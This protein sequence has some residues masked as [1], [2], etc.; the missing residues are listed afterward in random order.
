MRRA[1]IYAAFDGHQD[2]NFKPYVFK[3]ADFGKTWASIASDLPGDGPVHVITEHHRNR[4]LLFV[5]TEFGVFFS[6]DGGG[7]WV[8]LRNN[9]P[10]VAVHD[11]VIHPRENDLVLGT[12]GRGFWIL[13]DLAPIE[14]LTPDTLSG[15]ARLFPIRRAWQLHRFARG[16]NATGQQRFIA[17]NPPDGAIVSYYARKDD[18]VEI[19]VIDA[20]GGVIRRLA[21][22]KAASRTGIFRVT[23]DLRYPSPAP[24]RGGDGEDEGVFSG[25]RGPFVLPGKYDVRMRVGGAEQ[26]QTVEVVPD[27]QVTLSTADRGTWHQ[28]LLRLADMYRVSRASLTMLD[29]LRADLAA[30]RAALAAAGPKAEAL[31]SDE[32]AATAEIVALERLLRGEPS[33]G[34]AL[35][36]GPPALAQQIA[37]LLSGVEASTALPTADQERL[38]R[39]SHERLGEVVTRVERPDHHHSPWSLH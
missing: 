1:R 30:A 23:W 17:P 27:P 16:R 14:G 2:N 32:Q 8:P 38:T 24:A 39:R 37:Q 5:G 26:R 36:P 33:R 9:L 3:S 18:R 6:V 15:A 12:H 35:T 22:G 7:R 28:T 34:I 21:D 11:I 10:T 29:R 31:K 4:N 25:P 20:Q 19:D 13:D